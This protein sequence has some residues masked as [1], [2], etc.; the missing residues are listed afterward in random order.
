MRSLLPLLAAGVL[1]SAAPA[2]AQYPGS[3]DPYAQPQYQP[4]D[5]DDDYYQPPADGG[6]MQAG[7]YTY[8][9]VHPI[10]YDVGQG[11]CTMT[12]PHVHPYA[13]FDVNLFR[14]HQNVF[15]FVGDP[16]DFGY[17]QSLFWYRGNHPM[18]VDAG[19]GYCYMSWPHRHPFA[20]PAQLRPYFHMTG[21]HFVYQGP[22]EQPYYRNRDR[23]VNYFNDYYRSSYYGNRY[24]RVRPRHVWGWG[25][26]YGRG[27]GGG[28]RFGVGVP[29]VGVQVGV[30]G[31]GVQVG[32]GYRQPPPRV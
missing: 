9:G 27:Y 28:V 10:P 8:G 31:V 3:P 21:G 20:P 1:F 18:P 15:Y 12:T 5:G 32:P 6:A 13:P 17:T 2:R 11:F 30:P 22:W 16:Y 26:G 29:G 4:D 19:G 23:Y 14:R 24:Y 25:P 7:A